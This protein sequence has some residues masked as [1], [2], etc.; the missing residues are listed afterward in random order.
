MTD[1]KI[2]AQA[3]IKEA[4][5]H[6]EFSIARAAMLQGEVER[7]RAENARLQA[8]IGRNADGGMRP[9]STAI[10]PGVEGLLR[11]VSSVVLPDG[12]LRSIDPAALKPP[13]SPGF[14]A[15]AGLPRQ[16]DTM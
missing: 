9:S 11:P 5:M 13:G 14:D 3:L 4:G 7:L 10:I 1:V 12:S 15:R 2:S 6:H 16:D 8:E